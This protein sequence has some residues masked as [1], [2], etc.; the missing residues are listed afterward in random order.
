[1]ADLIPAEEI[2]S[3]LVGLGVVQ[4]QDAPPSVL[5]P[6]IW[7]NPRDEAPEPREGEDVA[8]TVFSEAEIPRDWYE[9]FLQ[10]RIFDFVVRS[11]KKVEG[12][13]VQRAIRAAFEEKK[14]V[15]FGQ[16]RIEWSKLFRGE[17]P[18]T[19][20]ETSYTSIQSFRI[21]YRIVSL[22]V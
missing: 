11:R 6:S 2:R 13:L 9:G 3:Y 19:S 17:Q 5:H 7:L 14:G 15:M 22:T 20:D 12:E 8:V 1:M 10:E 21:A 4:A 18:V 16:L